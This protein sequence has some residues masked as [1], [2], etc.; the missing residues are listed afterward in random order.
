MKTLAQPDVAAAVLA[1]LRTVRPDS[2]RRFG[3]MSPQQMVCHLADSLRMALGL[4]AMT[5]V[6]RRL[7][8]A[9]LKWLALY[10]P[11]PWPRGIRTRP[12][13][14]AQRGGTRPGDFEADVAE[15]EGLMARLVADAGQ[16]Q[17]RAHPLFGAMT[18]ADWLRWAFKHADHHLRQF[19]A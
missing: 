10:A 8:S 17:G 13:L 11:L 4:K 9:A 16:L 15:L 19:G 3:R 7:P 12:E 5:P 14:D 2:P 18:P 1:R 6:R